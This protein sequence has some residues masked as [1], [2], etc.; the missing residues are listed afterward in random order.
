MR[1]GPAAGAHGGDPLHRHLALAVEATGLGLWTWELQTDRLTWSE[2]NRELFGWED[3]T[4]LDIA[5]YMD[6]VLPEDR[7]LVRTAYR[8]ATDRLG[9]GDFSME[10]RIRTPAGDVR[11]LLAHGRLV[12]HPGQPPIVVGTSL[13]VTERRAA[14]ERSALLSHEMAHRS[15]NGLAVIMA[16]VSQTARSAQSVEAF[17][18]A[19]L[20]RIAAM[21]TSQD[22]VTEAS[23]AALPFAELAAKALAPF[24]ASQIDI[25][26]DLDQL[27]LHSELVIGVTLLLHELATNATKYGAL[28]TPR[29]RVTIE[30]LEAPDGRARLRWRER[31]GPAPAE[32][33]RVGFG[34]RLMQL[35]LR[36]FGGRIDPEFGPEGFTAVLD[37]P[38]PG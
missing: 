15:K 38:T 31:G 35:A 36:P 25:S 34:S 14:E 23:G 2:R 20:A 6:A 24:A 9:G 37:I 33:R 4:P 19:V 8:S 16:M 28:S 7:E 30:R 18:Q 17:E 1:G 3:D 29:G 21:A 11:W 32:A 12:N 27:D 26:P 22:M 13:D 10:Y 5:A